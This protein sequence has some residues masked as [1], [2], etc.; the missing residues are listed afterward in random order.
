MKRSDTSTVGVSPVIA[1]IL[2]VA[3]TVLMAGTVMMYV[4]GFAQDLLNTQ[5]QASFDI[6]DRPI[7]DGSICEGI[8]E[9]IEYEI[10]V[11][12]ISAT[13]LDSSTIR[14]HGGTVVPPGQSELTSVGDRI[15][16]CSEEQGSFVIVGEYEGTDSVLRDYSR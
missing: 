14:D 7:S 1:V 3:I 8:S 5:P 6:Q 16:V 15:T 13:H 10:T 4:M 9:D 12:V 2:M 11:T